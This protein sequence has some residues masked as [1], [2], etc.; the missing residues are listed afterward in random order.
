MPPF[1]PGE[2]SR[3]ALEGLK[4]E[5]VWQVAKLLSFSRLYDIYG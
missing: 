3:E 1:Y 2:I 5:A 4:Q